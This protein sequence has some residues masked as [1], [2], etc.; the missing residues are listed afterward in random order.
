MSLQSMPP[1][2]LHLTH[3]TVAEAQRGGATQVLVSSQR[4]RAA[5]MNVGAAAASGDI[6]VFM[7]AD[8]TK[9]PADLPQ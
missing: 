5:Q 9:P 3:R 2:F 1:N 8:T 7:H 6:L 4:G